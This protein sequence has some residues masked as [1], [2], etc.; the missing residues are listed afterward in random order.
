[1]FKYKQKT[2]KMFF[3]F[4]KFFLISMTKK[5]YIDCYNFSK[6][7]FLSIYKFFKHN[8]LISQVKFLFFENLRHNMHRKSHL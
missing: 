7:A 5:D 6:H 1:M 2:L 8:E 3:L 4:V